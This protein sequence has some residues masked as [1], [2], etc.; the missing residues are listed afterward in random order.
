[1]RIQEPGADADGLLSGE[2]RVQELRL[3]HDSEE[4]DMLHILLLWRCD[5]PSDATVII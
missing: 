3:H 2:I 5:V 1:M 4:R